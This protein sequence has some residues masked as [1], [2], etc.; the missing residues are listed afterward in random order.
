MLFWE[1]EAPGVSI[2][3]DTIL[4]GMLDMRMPAKVTSHAV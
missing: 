1:G 4:P 2:A 3:F